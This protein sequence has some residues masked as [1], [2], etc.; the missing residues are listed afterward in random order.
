MVDGLEI[1]DG[2]DVAFVQVMT[3]TRVRTGRSDSDELLEA[4]SLK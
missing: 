1:V 4:L 2:R 3:G